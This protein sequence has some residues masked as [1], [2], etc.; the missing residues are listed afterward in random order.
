MTKHRQR[1]RKKHRRRHHRHSMFSGINHYAKQHSHDLEKVQKKATERYNG[2]KRESRR[3][4]VP[5]LKKNI[6]NGADN[7]AKLEK[8]VAESDLTGKVR[9]A[10]NKSVDSLK[11]VKL[12]PMDKI[13]ESLKTNGKKA[14]I[15]LIAVTLA[16]TIVFI[17]FKMSMAAFF[18]KKGTEAAKS[19]MLKRA[20]EEIP[21][22]GDAAADVL[23]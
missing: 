12:N 6:Q 13:I 16:L 22:V 4:Y 3:H 15:I 9:G 10:F 19:G 23:T 7:V 20:L 2:F 11:K 18:V 1:R 17:L 21:V 5:A 14:A 8:N